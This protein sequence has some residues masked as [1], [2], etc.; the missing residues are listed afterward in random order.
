MDVI[1]TTPAGLAEMRECL[2][3]DKK[4]GAIKALRRT[5]TPPEGEKSISLR[6]A[7][8]AV[9]RYQHDE[10]GDIRYKGSLAD[11]KPITAGP[12]VKEIV[13]DFGG[14]PVTVDVETMELKALSQLESLGLEACG[15]M[16][17]L[18]QVIKAFG[19]GKRIGVINESR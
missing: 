15:R 1:I 12:V 16:L 18:C 9:E 13:C 3:K 14:G 8:L 19:E 17:E 5:A 11:G 6:E 7:K 10:M 2:E 4:I